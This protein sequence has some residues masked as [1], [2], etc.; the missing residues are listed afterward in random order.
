MQ[1][2]AACN[3][4][5]RY[6]G[7]HEFRNQVIE[8]DRETCLNNCLFYCKLFLIFNIKVLD[9][10]ECRVLKSKVY[11]LIPRKLSKDSRSCS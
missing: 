1:Q 7:G 3:I 8:Q 5:D 2:H 6:S 4:N 9:V 10:I 11:Y